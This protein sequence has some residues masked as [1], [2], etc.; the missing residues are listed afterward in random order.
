M[1]GLKKGIGV[2]LCCLAV[3]GMFSAGTLPVQAAQ[4][5]HTKFLVGADQRISNYVTKDGHYELWGRK[6][7][8]PNCKYSYYGDTHGVWIGAHTWV[9]QKGEDGRWVDICIGCGSKK[10][11]F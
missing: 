2:L 9:N 3:M 11:D 1:K 6:Y 4:C 8:C 10:S 7:E 5:D